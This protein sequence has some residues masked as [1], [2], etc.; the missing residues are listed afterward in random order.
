M[1]IEQMKVGFMDVFCYIVSCPNTKEALVI[2][3]AGDEERIVSRVKEK[4]L[5]LKYIVNTHGHPDHTCGNFKMKDITGAKIIIHELDEQMFNS[6][7]GNEIARQWGFTPSPPADITVKDGDY[8]TV[9]DVSLKVIHT[10]GH[11]PG[12]VCLL[13]EGNLFSGD[14]LFV[15]AIGRT[16]L[17]GASMEQF[18]DS[19]KKKLLTLPGETIVW[20]GHDYGVSPSSTIEAEIRTNPYL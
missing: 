8:I 4:E 6:T 2:D 18:M 17:P 1:D 15:G 9:G 14:T 20:P 10:P 3:P 19:I 5:D 13:G 7:H 16:D 11:S 12:G